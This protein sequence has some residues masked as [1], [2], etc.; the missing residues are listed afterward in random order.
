MYSFLIV[1]FMTAL[2][3]LVMIFAAEP[4][5]K[6]L[7]IALGIYLV[8]SGFYTL[9]YMLKLVEEKSYKIGIAIRGGLSLV[10][11]FIC[12]IFPAT[13]VDF[14]WKSMMAILGI[15]ALCSAA[16]E[17]YAIRILSSAGRDVRRY[18]IEILITISVA[19]VLFML[20]TSFGFNII[21]I[22]GI[23]LIVIA[24][25]LA[26]SGWKNRDIVQK[27]AEVVDED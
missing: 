5:I 6:V 24:G 16:I 21:K 27:D 2:L 17:I 7:V 20:P 3:G 19:I 8:V 10:I 14:A 12:I 4:I 11:G 25:I 26:F 9:L 13:S 23:V 1:P 15:Y 22:G 18:V